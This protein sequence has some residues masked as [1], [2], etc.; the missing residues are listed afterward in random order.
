MIVD[1]CQLDRASKMREIPSAMMID[2][3]HTTKTGWNWQGRKTKGISYSEHQI[4]HAPSD[5]N[6][7]ALPTQETP[8]LPQKTPIFPWSI[9]QFYL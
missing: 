4:N 1:E 5:E 6:T 9:N 8:K 7:F 2:N 3:N